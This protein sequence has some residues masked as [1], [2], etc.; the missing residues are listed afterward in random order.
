MGSGR[1]KTVNAEKKRIRI[2]TFY[3]SNLQFLEPEIKRKLIRKI[4]E[5][6]KLNLVHVKQHLM[7]IQKDGEAKE[8]FRFSR[9]KE[10]TH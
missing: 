6:K 5:Q 7:R 2:E 1:P 10:K 8:Y 3:M 9:N 4:K